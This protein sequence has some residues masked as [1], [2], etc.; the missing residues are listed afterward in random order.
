MAGP[1]P[2]TADHEATFEV[3][4]GVLVLERLG[5]ASVLLVLVFRVLEVPLLLIGK[6]LDDDEEEGS[7][8]KCQIGK[9]KDLCALVVR[10]D[11][12]RVGRRSDEQKQ[13]RLGNGNE[14]QVED[15]KHKS[16]V[17][18]RAH[19]LP[20]VILRADRVASFAPIVEGQASLSIDPS[21]CMNSK[22]MGLEIVRLRSKAR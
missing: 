1:R 6:V 8:R 15:R 14:R 22:R 5:N 18:F 12:E 7:A 20:A 4:S 3:L 21:Q 16:V 11:N 19:N 17:H 10:S 13:Q 9:S 2:E